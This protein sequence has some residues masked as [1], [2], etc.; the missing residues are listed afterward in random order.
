MRA[1]S[2]SQRHALLQHA[3]LQHA[4]PIGFF[5]A[6]VGVNNW[7]PVGIN[8]WAVRALLCARLSIG[9]RAAPQSAVRAA[10]QSEA[11][12][13]NQR[14]AIIEER[15]GIQQPSERNHQHQHNP[16]SSAQYLSS[17]Q[18]RGEWQGRVQ[19]FLALCCAQLNTRDS[20]YALGKTFSGVSPA[21][22]AGGYIATIAVSA[23]A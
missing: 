21:N 16:S 17:Q 18:Q 8:N 2:E 19:L 4:L 13:S 23:Q 3:L 7:A 20:C 5:R 15:S 9:I 22:S 1:N 10:P 12:Q 11:C 14:S 6:L